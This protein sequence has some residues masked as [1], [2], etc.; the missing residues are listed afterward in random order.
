MKLSPVDPA[1]PVVPY[2]GGKRALSHRL[3]SM[4]DATPHDLFADVFVGGGGIFFRRRRRPRK[5]V[6][7]D[8]NGE[9]MNLFRMMQRHHQALLDHL[10]VQLASRED[11]Q[12]MVGMDPGHLTEIERAARFIY[13]QRL[14]FG[15]KIQG[16]NYGVNRTGPARFDLRKLMPSV[17]RAHRRLQGVD[18]ERL[19][20]E[21]LLKRYDRPGT[22]FYL[23][24]PYHGC[25]TDYGAGIFSE[26]DF[27]R[28]RDLL[29]RLQGRFILSIND[30]PQ[31]R[32]I[33]RVF[34]MEEVSLHYRVSGKATPA[35]ELIFVG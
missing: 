31:I 9:V 32:E 34:D 30:T 20:Y 13:L 33:F 21:E 16:Q 25:E 4:I 35:R 23:D 2:L 3:T 15:G 29:E 5:E 11:F 8:I 28:L 17:H 7:N 19:N 12:R 14:A 1:L 10:A 18:I 22:L 24:P 6:I 26:A 27:V